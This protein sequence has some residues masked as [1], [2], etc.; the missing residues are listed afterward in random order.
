[1]LLVAQVTVNC[2][3]MKGMNSLFGLKIQFVV[4]QELLVAVAVSIAHL[5]NNM[6]KWYLF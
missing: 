4:G 5:K 6:L 1:M 3:Q 2:F